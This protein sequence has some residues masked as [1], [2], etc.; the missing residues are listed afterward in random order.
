[1]SSDVVLYLYYYVIECKAVAGGGARTPELLTELWCW[2]HRLAVALEKCKAF[3]LLDTSLL[4]HLLD[5][6]TSSGCGEG[7]A[8]PSGH[9]PQGS[10]SSLTVST[11]G[12][13]SVVA[14]SSR[15]RSCEV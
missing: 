5:R 7:L 10:G 2:L 8:G 6:A 9:A 4:E 14:S 11:G 15:S 1:M 3:L 13:A 12:G